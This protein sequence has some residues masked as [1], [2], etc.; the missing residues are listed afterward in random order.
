MAD[1]SNSGEEL[2]ISSLDFGRGN[3]EIHLYS[4]IVNK[5]SLNSNLFS[6][7]Y[8]FMITN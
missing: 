4:T 1:A 2:L 6:N 7:H 5:I 8:T 3:L